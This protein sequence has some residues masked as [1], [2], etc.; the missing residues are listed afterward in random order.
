M[1]EDDKRTLE[2]EYEATMAVN[3]WIERIKRL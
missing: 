1:D 2:R 3:D